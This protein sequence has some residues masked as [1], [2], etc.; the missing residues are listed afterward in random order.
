MTRCVRDRTLWLLS[1]GEASPEARAHVASCVACT[2]RLRH[3]QRDLHRL[4]A[5]LT[6]PPPQIALARS[7]PRGVPWL[8]AAVALAALLITIW[9]GP[10]WQ[11]AAPPTPPME[12]SQESIWPFIERVS[13]ALFAAIE[14]GAVE[15]ADLPY[16]LTDLQAALAGE[17]PCEEQG[18]SWLLECDE[19]VLPFIFGEY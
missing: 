3:L 9:V 7:S 11:P 15:T 2:E 17:W 18:T 1:E 4:R 6:V 19:D 14:V 5:V 10:W 12:A 13:E 16:D 8:T